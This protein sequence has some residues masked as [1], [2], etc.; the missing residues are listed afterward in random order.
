M[1][2]IVQRLGTGKLRRRKSP[3]QLDERER[4]TAREC[5]EPL[6]DG[7]INARRRGGFEQG[8]GSLGV[9]AFQYQFLE[10]ACRK[11]AFTF[12]D[13]KDESHL[14][15]LESSRG[16]DERVQRGAIEPVHVIDGDE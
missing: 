3:R 12:S 9:E 15:C 5:V 8:R 16:K 10:D 6:S 11:S 13:G 1:K 4:I 2:R 14:V 7:R